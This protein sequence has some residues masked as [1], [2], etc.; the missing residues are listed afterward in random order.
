MNDDPSI[1]PIEAFIWIFSKDLREIDP[2]GVKA[3]EIT[4]RLH[5]ALSTQ[6]IIYLDQACRQAAKYGP[7]MEL[8]DV[9]DRVAF[10]C[11]WRRDG[12]ERPPGKYHPKC[13]ARFV[14]LD[15]P[16]PPPDVP[17]RMRRLRVVGG[18]A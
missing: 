5:Q 17:P 14:D 6:K 3:A 15:E 2:E 16:Q 8:D 1:D 12:G 11:P 13:R 18:R 4:K 9:L 7:E 10:D